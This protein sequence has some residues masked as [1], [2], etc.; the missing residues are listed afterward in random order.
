MPVE[1]IGEVGTPGATPVDFCP[2]H[3]RHPAHC[4][5]VRTAAAGHGVGSPVA[6]A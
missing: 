1:I 6:G 4:Q 5:G 3:S 2:G